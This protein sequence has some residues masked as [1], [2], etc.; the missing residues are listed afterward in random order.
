MS[1]R[2]GLIGAGAMGVHHAKI[3]AEEVGGCALTA[4][5][6]ADRDRAGKL[7]AV[8]GVSRLED[9]GLKLI[10]DPAIDAI[11]IASPDATHFD[12]VMECLKQHK[13][14]LCEKPLA[15]TSAQC[16]QIAEAE[17]AG[18]KRL[19]QVGFMRR[20]DSGY[21]D[22]KAKHEAGT[23]GQPLLMHCIHRVPRSLPYLNADTIPLSSAVH[24]IDIARFL[25]GEEFMRAL[26]RTSRPSRRA[27]DRAPQFYL[28]ETT[29]GILVDIEIFVDAQYGYDVRAELVLESGT[30][31]LVPPNAS[32][33]R[34]NSLSGKAVSDDWTGRFDAA[35]ENQARAWVKS[36]NTGIPVGASAWDGYVATKLGEECVAS[37]KA[38]SE[39]HLAIEAMPAFYRN[40]I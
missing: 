3:F 24:E 30:I 36:V 28:L 22:M 17:I 11:V 23:F 33:V 16:R 25:T 14:V 12:L 37:L 32:S 35:Y 19:V 13:S 31:S 38:K 34:S 9:D 8:L 5:A 1:L 21:L 18:G 10:R 39:R 4:I 26:V 20:F 15:V 6:D 7:A 2:I 29:T 27:A 40:T